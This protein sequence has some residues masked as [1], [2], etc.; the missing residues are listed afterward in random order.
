MQQSW[1]QLAGNHERQLL[2]FDPDRCGPSDRYA[3]SLLTPDVFAWLKSL[4][5]NA[6]IG[7]E[8]LLCHGTPASDLEYFLETVTPDFVRTATAYEIEQRLGDTPAQ[9]I[10]CGHTH[11]PRVV[12]TRTGKLIVNP[13]S[14]GLPASDDVKP[15]PHR[16]ETGAPDA[17]YAIVEKRNGQWSAALLTIPY[18]YEAAVEL[19]RKRGRP[20]W[21]SAL[22]SGYLLPGEPVHNVS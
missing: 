18:H 5:S 3:H 6:S 22:R 4:P 10:A 11:L 9:L 16:M 17:R 20:E 15:F 8:I 12:R 13:G 7:D 2:D 21:E 19:A 14:V 1:V